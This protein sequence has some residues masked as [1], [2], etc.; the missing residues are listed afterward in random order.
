MNPVCDPH[1]AGQRIANAFK[2]TAYLDL[3]SG[4]SLKSIGVSIKW[5]T[6][7]TPCKM[8]LGDQV[9]RYGSNGTFIRNSA[10]K[11]LSVQALYVN[12]RE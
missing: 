2:A 6:V 9:Y 4:N 7:Y 5:R 1:Y 8:I 10:Y 3:R 11:L 12:W